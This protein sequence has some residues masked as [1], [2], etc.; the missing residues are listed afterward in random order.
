MKTVLYYFSATG[1]NLAVAKDLANELEEPVEIIPITKLTKE[2]RIEADYDR[3]GIIFPV[4]VRDVPVIVEEFAK[5][6]AT[7][8][9]AYVFAICTYHLN[10][11][12]A[13]FNL[14][15]ILEQRGISLSSGF[16]INM[17][18]MS[19]LA[20]DFTSTDEE[21]ESRLAQEKIRIKEVASLI[22]RREPAAIEG[23]Y[24]KA[25]EYESK[26]FLNHIYKVVEQFWVN[27]NCNLCG[28]CEKVCPLGTV[29]LLDKKV[30]WEG[31]CE[32]CQSCLHWCPTKAIQNGSNSVK[33]RRYHHPDIKVT[34][35]INSR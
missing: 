9:E 4:Y 7:K 8:K 15:S 27:D 11:F 19:V 13:L 1:N 3:I 2:D 10:P 21:N 18:G 33:C 24:N 25:E 14:N 26:H 23:V 17:P 31:S 5:R 22:R 28:I 35:I 30:V 16:T 34:E 6:L 32:H 12:N 29:K 20:V